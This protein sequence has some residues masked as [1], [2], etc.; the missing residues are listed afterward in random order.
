MKIAFVT[1]NIHK[2]REA[3]GILQGVIEV[4]HIPLEIPELRS[5]SVGEISALKAAFAWEQLK[6]PVIADDTGFFIP[7]LN[8]FPGTCA[9]FVQKTIG[10]QSILNLLAGYRNRSAWFETAVAYHDREIQ[11][12]FTGRIDGTIVLPKGCG[13]FGYDPIFEYDGKTLAEMNEEEK[14]RISHRAQ[15]FVALRDWLILHQSG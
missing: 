1:S 7:A 4:E 2:A 14:N 8:G 13:G 9:A 10:N 12:V 5:D 6:C 11:K 3:A 15:A